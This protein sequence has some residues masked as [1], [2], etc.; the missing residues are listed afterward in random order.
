MLILAIDTSTSILSLALVSDE[1]TLAVVNENTKHNQSEILMSRIES[2]MNECN[3][4]PTDLEKIAVAVGPG[5][6]TG[7]RVGVAAAKS[8]GYALQIPVVA[9]SSLEV[10]A[11]AAVFYD[12]RIPMINARRDTVFSGVY[13]YDGT[14]IIPDGHYKMANL[15][16][17]LIL[18][19]FSFDIVTFIGDGATLHKEFLLE[20]WPEAQVVSESEFKSNKAEV[21]ATLAVSRLPEENIHTLVPNYLRKTEAQMNAGV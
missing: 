15:I 12:I 8:L 20:K 17:E 19:V 6:Y 11:M 4:K 18:N 13:D 21:L 9:V 5:S 7:I 10:M 2:M 1:Q 14:V 3:L 16:D